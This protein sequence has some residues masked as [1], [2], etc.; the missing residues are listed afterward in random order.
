MLGLSL[1]VVS[2]AFVMQTG[3]DGRVHFV[4]L[5]RFPL[6]ELCGSR[7]LYG[8]TCPGCGLTRSVIALADGD[9]AAS[10][11]YH[12]IGWLMALAILLQVPYRVYALRELK[13]GIVERAWP[14]WF[15]ILLIAALLINWL[16]GIL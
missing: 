16:A 14:K 7:L 3:V 15:G 5:S 6:P 8:V 12:R 9:L 1:V 11:R 13:T 4:G 10:L 2:L